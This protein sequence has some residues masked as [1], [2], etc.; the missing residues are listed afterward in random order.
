MEQNNLSKGSTDNCEAA[1][2]P[3]QSI[4]ARIF[5]L[6]AFF[7]KLRRIASLRA[8]ARSRMTL[9]TTWDCKESQA[10]SLLVLKYFA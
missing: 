2:P 5:P 7:D 8:N 9:A 6:H 1:Q 3:Q 10:L 4:F